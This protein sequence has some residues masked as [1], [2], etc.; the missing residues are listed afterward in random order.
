MTKQEKTSIATVYRFVRRELLSQWQKIA[1]LLRP[2]NAWVDRSESDSAS[3]RGHQAG[4]NRKKNDEKPDA[5][6]STTP[7]ATK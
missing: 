2:C 3:S 4:R 5:V 1:D 6:D 7:N